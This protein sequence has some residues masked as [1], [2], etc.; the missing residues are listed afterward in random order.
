MAT[1]DPGSPAGAAIQVSGLVVRYGGVV[2][3]DGISF[4]AAPGQVLALLGPNGAGKTSTV[5]TLEG[6]RRPTAGR[7]E[8]LGL[9]PIADRA[10]LTPRIGVML[11]RGGVYPSMSA[12]Q[13]LRLFAAYYDHAADPE[14]LVRLVGLEEVAATP[15]RRLSGGEQQRL[16]LALAL[17]GRPEVAFLDEPTAGVDPAG[18]LA[19]RQVV[20]DLREAGACVVLATHE[21]EEAERLADEVLILDHGHVVAAGTPA[22]LRVAGEGREIRFAAAAGLDAAGLSEALGAPVVEER[23]GEYRADTDATPAAVARLTAWLADHDLPLADLRAGRQKL[24]DVFLRLVAEGAT[25]NDTAEAKRQG[26][27]LRPGRRT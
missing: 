9:D 25:D 18:R 8:V 24:E 14:D 19:V 1:A 11:Q 22:Q 12:A 15:W 21:L 23:P 16:S 26:L 27:G 2:A 20:R 17:V 10:A 4:S 6:Y 3:V 7:V 5:E 13:A